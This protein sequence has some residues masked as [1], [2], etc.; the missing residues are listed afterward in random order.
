MV[1]RVYGYSGKVRPKDYQGVKF[2][3]DESV[4]LGKYPTFSWSV[5]AFTNWLTQNAVNISVGAISTMLGSALSL[6]VGVA[7]ANPIGIAGGII[8][9]SQSI[10]NTFGQ[11][12]QASMLPNTAQGNANSGDVSFV[13]NINRF[14]IMHMRAKKEYLERV[15]NYLTR[16]G[17][18]IDKLETPNITGR[19]YWNYVEIGATEEIGYGSVP[20]KFMDIINNACRKGVTIWHNH[21]NVGNYSLNNSIV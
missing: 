21:S 6:S 2:N 7:T 5:D 8:S 10:A 11:L 1:Y 17:Y 14:K 9:A 19:K 16:F 4:Q 3:E 18:K 12:Y 20:S 13:F 15:D